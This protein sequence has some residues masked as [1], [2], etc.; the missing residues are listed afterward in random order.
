MT[1]VGWERPTY[2]DEYRVTETAEEAL[3]SMGL[4]EEEMA[5][6]RRASEIFHRD[7]RI[8][9]CGHPVS[10]HKDEAGVGIIFC[11]PSRMLCPCQEPYPVIEVR[12]T[13]LFVF[14]TTG[15]GPE[16]ALQRGIDKCR[17]KGIDITWLVP[18]RCERPGCGGTRDVQSTPLSSR[19]RPIPEESRI[20]VL[21][22][23]GCRSGL[24]P[25][26]DITGPVSVPD[27]TEA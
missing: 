11:R 10:R 21:M 27:L 17:E 22:C 14:R 24:E 6:G 19:M 9:A 26:M 25:G 2:G 12:D 16:H 7:G 13:R 4:T 23:I 8:C 15:I 5:K 20:N 1:T 3:L 18:K